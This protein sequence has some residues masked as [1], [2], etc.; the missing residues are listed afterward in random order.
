[1]TKRA[2]IIASIIGLVATVVSAIVVRNAA[3]DETT[4][5]LVGLLNTIAAGIAGR[6]IV[7]PRG[8]YRFFTLGIV[9]F[10]G[11]AAAILT[12]AVTNYLINQEVIFGKATGAIT[13][14]VL[15]TA[16]VGFVFYLL[17]ATVY[18]FAGK[19]QGIWVG[20]RVGLLLLLLLS[21]VPVLNV[22][23]L[24]AFTVTAF[25]RRR[26]TPKPPAA[27]E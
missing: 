5:L 2:L 18:G 9:V 26:S 25:V 12:S 15:V 22:A 23:G 17:A 14:A 27:S 20:P 1:M 24:A 6:V 10:S 21:V 11:A 3:E 7:G 16:I 19:R 4:N 13:G 8:V